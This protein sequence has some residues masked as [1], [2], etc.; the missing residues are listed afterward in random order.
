MIYDTF[1]FKVPGQLDNSQNIDSTWRTF[2]L[3]LIDPQH[4]HKRYLNCP[5][6][7]LGS[8]RLTVTKFHV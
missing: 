1:T 2:E 6:S 3:T 8:F 4:R 7:Q 5:I